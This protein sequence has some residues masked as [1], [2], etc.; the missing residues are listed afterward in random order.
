M[1]NVAAA[2]GLGVFLFVPGT[3]GAAKEPVAELFESAGAVV[4][5]TESE[6][7]V[8]TA[9]AGCMPGFVARMAEAFAAA[10]ANGGLAP[11][12]ALQVSLGGLA[13]A[14][15]LVADEGDPAAVIATAATPGGMTAAGLAAL[16][17]HDIGG[18]IE[19]AVRAAAVKASGLA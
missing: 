7:D 6:Y 8:A 10:G 11:S 17:E 19:A 4:E 13:G 14:A 18:T 3:L 15:A 9:I 5:V 2:L 1:P 16:D 12:T